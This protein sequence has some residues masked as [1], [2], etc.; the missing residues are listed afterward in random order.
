MSLI[1][2]SP[3]AANLGRW[4]ATPVS[5]YTGAVQINLPLHEVR[6]GGLQ[7]PISLSYNTTGQR[8]EEVAGWTGLG[9]TLNAGGVVTRV[10][11]SRPDDLRPPAGGLNFLRLVHTIG[12][13]E[14]ETNAMYLE[15]ISHGCYDAQPD[16]FFF[17]FNG[18]TGRFAFD[19]QGQ[20]VVSSTSPITATPR[21]STAVNTPQSGSIVGWE[22]TTPDGAKYTFAETETTQQYSPG[23][24]AS[25]CTPTRGIEYISSWYLTKITDVNREHAIEFAYDPYR[26]NYAFR[27]SESIKVP[28]DNCSFSQAGQLIS[29]YSQLDHRAVRLRRITTSDR[30]T[31]LFDAGA[32]RT[33][34]LGLTGRYTPNWRQLDRIRVRADGADLKTFAF[35]Y[36][37]NHPTGRLTLGSIQERGIGGATKPPH[38]FTYH[39]LSLPDDVRSK[40]QDH[41][42][43]YNGA[44]NNSLIAGARLLSLQGPYEATGANR[45]VNPAF[46]QSGMLTQL[47]YPTG[48]HSVFEYENND[49]SYIQKDSL[50][51]YATFTATY[52]L[53]IGT[54]DIPPGPSSQQNCGSRQRSFTVAPNPARPD[55]E[56][57]VH[58]TWSGSNLGKA[59]GFR[60]YVRILNS[61]GMAIY[62]PRV[63]YVGV[64]D[65][66][67]QNCPECSD[68]LMLAPGTYSLL[69]YSCNPFTEYPNTPRCSGGPYAEIAVSYLQYV[70]QQPIRRKL[71]GGL[72][73]K[74]VRDHASAHDLQPAVRQY[75]Y[76]AQADSSRSAGVIY[77]APLYVY[78]SWEWFE[79][80]P[81]TW[82]K[83]N[84]QMRTAQNATVL[85]TTQGSS[86]GYREVTEWRGNNGVGG[87]TVYRYTSPREY[88][89]ALDQRP[90]FVP[91]TSQ[92]HMTGLLIEQTD[93]RAVKNSFIPVKRAVQEFKQ[94]SASIYGIGAA[95]P[96]SSYG[97]NKPDWYQIGAYELR[98]GHTQLARREERVYDP[99]GQTWHGQTTTVSYNAAGTQ[100]RT[101]ATPTADG[102][103]LDSYY[104]PNDYRQPSATLR[105]MADALYLVPVEVVTERVHRG[106]TA[107]VGVLYNTYAQDAGRLRLAAQG[108]LRTAQPLPKRSYRYSY[109]QAE[110]AADSR[111]GSE[112]VI[113]RY[114]T[115]G[116]ITQLHRKNGTPVARLWGTQRQEL[117]AE[118]TGAP[119]PT[120][121]ATSFEPHA[122][123]RWQCPPA[124][125]VAYLP[126]GHAGRWLCRL[127]AGG[128]VSRDSLPSGQYVLSV[129]AE[130]APAI[131]VNGLLVPASSQAAGPVDKHGLRQ[132]TATVKA[133]SAS[134]TVAL[135]VPGGR[136]ALALDELRL[137]PVGAQLITYTYD[138]LV[139]MTSQTDPSGRTTTYEYDGLSRLVRARDEQGRIL[140]QQQ[141][142]YAGQ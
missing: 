55:D 63:A 102:T 134:N 50:N 35:T 11:R 25:N 72:R 105:A 34:T 29:S 119:Y 30:D 4:A 83:C 15:M 7:V 108:T 46:T 137:H 41:W 22:L 40:S 135:A 51:E 14:V 113:D 45:D 12:P 89:D 97:V 68:E 21:Y 69:V 107:V 118:A 62:N 129:W 36:L 86:V 117:V 9:W 98:L 32:L 70:N 66:Y 28:L 130:A 31:V 103:R 101:R 58:V 73:I 78:G 75:S 87:K 48:G 67:E 24:N 95:Y 99:E 90:P 74:S 76:R 33:D 81:N 124:P 61:Q 88:L 56:R 82:Y 104:Y 140:S 120:V 100:V 121:A 122:P 1:P 54:D 126:G 23:N 109:Q 92:S 125:L 42:G 131:Y 106:D 142:H 114:D 60:P 57:A 27:A 8:V 19:W 133:P 96:G 5:H 128:T 16:E 18:Y 141:Y 26:I 116:N 43:Y 3:E 138:P 136:S 38:R 115:A 49:Y 80:S 6:A 10:V 111:V 20:L 112:V 52:D 94:F 132:Y 85:G 47:E 65:C 123:G 13:F 37:P 127:A 53:T 91:P 71:A 39:P 77:A 79:A 110:G 44:T 84:Y 2:P 139:G 59:N 17:N 93:Y 64:G